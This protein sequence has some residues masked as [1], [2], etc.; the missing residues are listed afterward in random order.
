[1]KDEKHQEGG[2]ERLGRQV[3][4][5]EKRGSGLVICKCV[6]MTEGRE[7]LGR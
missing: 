7:G 5:G 1:M 6:M 4:R 2:H 3:R